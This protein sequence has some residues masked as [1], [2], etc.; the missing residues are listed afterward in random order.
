MT[1]LRTLF[2]GVSVLVALS[3]PAW[4]QCGPA[5]AVP[6][7]PPGGTAQ[8]EDMKEAAKAIEEYAEKM[9]AYADCLIA[10]AQD[11]IDTRNAVVEQ[12]NTQTEE[13]NARLAE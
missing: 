13:F 2:L 10:A 11:A 12:W 7:V 8:I 9:N 6:D 4:A 5:P 1:Q 3:A